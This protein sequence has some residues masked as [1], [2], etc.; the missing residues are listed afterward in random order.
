MP[1]DK[2]FIINLEFSKESIENARKQIKEK[3]REL[4]IKQGLSEEQI[5]AILYCYGKSLGK[6]NDNANN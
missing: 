5:E 4:L 1:N 2:P 6:V 3:Q